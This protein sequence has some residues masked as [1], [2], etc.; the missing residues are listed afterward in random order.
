MTV[1]I[2]KS[3][4]FTRFLRLGLM[5]VPLALTLAGSRPAYGQEFRGSIK[6]PPNYEPRA[7]N[8]HQ[9]SD[10]DDGS[11]PAERRNPVG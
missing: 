11:S 9:R 10:Y 1:T 4:Q 8:Q 5:L 6:G 3:V 7:R 2:F